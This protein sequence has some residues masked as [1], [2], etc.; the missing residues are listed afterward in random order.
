MNLKEYLESGVIEDYCLGVLPP[1]EM[2][3]VALNAE[4]FP[5]I[6][7]AIKAYELALKRYA[8]DKLSNDARKN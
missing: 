5:E 2:Q 6:K 1:R 3:V 8:Q 4:Q 7:A